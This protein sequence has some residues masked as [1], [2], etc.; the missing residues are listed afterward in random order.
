MRSVTPSRVRFWRSGAVPVGLGT[1]KERVAEA[2]HQRSPRRDRPL[3]K[4][5]CAALPTSLV[6]SELFGHEKG[7]FTGADQRKLGRFEMA[8]GGTLLL[9]EFGDLATEVQAKLL[10]VLQDGEFER[11]GA[12]GTLKVDVRI[13][14]ATNRD[15]EGAVRAGRFR[16]DLFYRLNVF[17][18]TVPPLRERREDIPLLLWYFVG[19]L[20]SATGKRI[21]RIPQELMQQFT[22]YDWPGNVRELANVVERAV[23]LSPGPVLRLD[24]TSPLGPRHPQ[25]AEHEDEPDRSRPRP[26][27]RRSLQD[28]E[29]NHIRDVLEECRWKV[30]GPGGAAEALGLKESTLRFQMKRLGVRRP[31]GR[32]SGRRRAESSPAP[33]TGRKGP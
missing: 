12:T 19:R 32:A 31:S 17:P 22:G 13:L 28:I 1:G 20:A 26:G 7:A 16:D 27:G 5:N 24:E 8:D 23:I 9:D 33:A 21:E 4:I 29:R 3:V 30:S 11:V 10:R 2:I 18:V 6:E 15:L 25:P 14:A